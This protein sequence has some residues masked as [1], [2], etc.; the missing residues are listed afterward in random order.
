MRV[1]AAWYAL[2]AAALLMFFSGCRRNEPWQLTNIR[3]HMP[4]LQFSLTSDQ[5]SPVTEKAVQG[6]IALV[7]F[8]YTHCPDVCPETLARLMNALEKLGSGARDVR[9]LF[10]SV[11]PA[12]DTPQAMRAYVQA[13]D[14]HHIMGLTGSVRQIEAL[15]RRYRV[16]Y[17][18]TSQSSKQNYDVMH[19]PTVYIFDRNQRARLIAKPADSADQIAHDLRLLIQNNR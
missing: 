8:G 6:R 5:G 4:D 11:D 19:S 15:A 10:V 16:T 18:Q 17:Q 12:R 13:F 9:I 3:G 2:L 7:Y 1:S 14:A